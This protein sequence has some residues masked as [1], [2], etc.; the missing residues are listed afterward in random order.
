M[1]LKSAVKMWK[2]NVTNMPCDRLVKTEEILQYNRLF[3]KSTRII[4]VKIMFV[5]NKYHVRRIGSITNNFS[6]TRY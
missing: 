5:R 6:S 4:F 3:F 2:N 1:R